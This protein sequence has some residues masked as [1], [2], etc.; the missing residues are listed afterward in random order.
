MFKITQGREVLIEFPHST[1]GVITDEILADLQSLA[2]GIS[3]HKLS[4]RYPSAQMAVMRDIAT[5]Q[6]KAIHTFGESIRR[7]ESEKPDGRDLAWAVTRQGLQQSTLNSVAAWKA[8]WF[9]CDSVV[10]ICCGLGSDLIALAAAVAGDGR[11]TGIDINSDVLAM[12]Q[13]NLRA[14]GQVAELRTIDVVAEAIDQ[15]IPTNSFLHIDP[16][17]RNDGKRHTRPEDLVPDWDRVRAMFAGCRGGVVKLAPAT[18]LTDTQASDV[19]RAW[20]S[21]SGS[22]REQSVFV[23]DLVSR[24]LN[25]H[26]ALK[27]GGRSAVVIR[28]GVP[29]T[30][31]DSGTLNSLTLTSTKTIE[32]FIIDLDPSIRAA[33]LTEVFAEASSIRPIDLASGFLTSDSVDQLEGYRSMVT[34]SRVLEVVGCDDRKL[35][36]CFRARD[37]Y[38]EVIKVRGADQSPETLS[39]RLKDC[40]SQPLGLWIG[41]NGKRTFAAIT[42]LG[43]RHVR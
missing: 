29:S 9:E 6:P 36:R 24:S 34:T 25:G 7:T 40:G 5:L 37:A 16:D 11:V 13:A 3:P 39:R 28:G 15:F 20:I 31:T 30:F 41:R 19:H 33:G 8:S 26:R 27:P 35:R 4:N 38:P 43:E 17:R 14:A 23:G 18:P 1:L 2:N 12:A 10:D 42:E 32:N 21:A 22:V